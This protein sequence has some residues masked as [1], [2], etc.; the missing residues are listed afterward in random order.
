MM[1]SRLENKVLVSLL[2]VCKEKGAVLISPIDLL[3]II[4]TEHLTLSELE[5]TLKDLSTDGYFD[6]VY[7][8]RRGE[9]VFCI[10]LLEKGKGYIRSESIEKRNLIKRFALTIGFAILSFLVGIILR[11]IF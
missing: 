6:L 3:K 5:K 8:D 1:L 10:T 2:N 9:K 7:S 11:K 4:G